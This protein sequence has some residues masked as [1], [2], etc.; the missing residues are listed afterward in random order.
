MCVFFFPYGVL[1]A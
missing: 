1:E